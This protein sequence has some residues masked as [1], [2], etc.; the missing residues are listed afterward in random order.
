[1]MSCSCQLLVI[2]KLFGCWTQ[3]N[4]TG[5]HE[6]VTW[7]TGQIEG[8]LKDILLAFKVKYLNSENYFAS[9]CSRGIEI[10]QDKLS[11]MHAMMCIALW[12]LFS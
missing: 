11:S 3:S 1:M 9:Y 2:Y 5:T 7:P 4:K 6:T 8:K 12:M 10:K